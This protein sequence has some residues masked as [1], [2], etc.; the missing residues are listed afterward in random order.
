[1]AV[2]AAIAEAIARA[3]RGRRNRRSIL[4]AL[5]HMRAI[6]EGEPAGRYLFA[7]ALDPGA[8]S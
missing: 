2:R 4:E 8:S 5:L 1:M 3:D 6:I 7:A